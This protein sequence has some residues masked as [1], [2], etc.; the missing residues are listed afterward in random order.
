MVCEICGKIINKSQYYDSVLCSNQCFV[1][2][3]WKKIISEKEKHII[4]DG[5]CYFD[6]GNNKPGVFRGFSGRR[7]WI[8]FK[9]GSTLTTNNL[10]H[11]GKIPEEFRDELPDTAEFYTPEQA[12]DTANQF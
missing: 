7:F 4:I 2:H 11:Q 3:F 9:D 12:G 1:K 10:W 5:G 8:R 6:A